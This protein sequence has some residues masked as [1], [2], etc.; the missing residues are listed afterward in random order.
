MHSRARFPHRRPGEAGQTVPYLVLFGAVLIGMCG[1]AIDLGN[2]YQQKQ[3]LQAAADSAALAGGSELPA[4]MAKASSAATT[5][6]AKNGKG[7]DSVTVS[8]TSDLTSNDSV[9]VQ[10]TRN[11]P[12]YFRPSSAS[13][14]STSR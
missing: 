1:L 13:R 2:W 5:N 12:T 6:Y 14:T 9:T 7:S 11:A 3:A 8:Q 4:G 10:A